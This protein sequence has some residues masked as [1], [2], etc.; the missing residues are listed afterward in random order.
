MAA[1]DILHRLERDQRRREWVTPREALRRIQEWYTD[2]S[3][4]SDLDGETL[5]SEGSVEGS[6]Q[7]KMD[8]KGGAMEVAL[9][10]FAQ[11][12]GWGA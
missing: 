11:R 1:Y 5:I 3:L 2:P 10:A 12:K 4:S 8:K 9:K 7:G 6:Q